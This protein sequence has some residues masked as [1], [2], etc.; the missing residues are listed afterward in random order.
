MF[1]AMRGWSRLAG[2]IAASGAA[3]CMLLFPGAAAAADLF[4]D[5]ETGVDTGTTCLQANPCDTLGYAISNS[6]AGDSI[7]VDNGTYTEAVTLN[8]GRSLVAQ[9]FVAGDG[10]APPLIDG[11]AS[12]GITA[13]GSGGGLIRGVR[14][15]GETAG[16]LLNAET[17]VDESVFDEPAAA[18]AVGVQ[19]NSGGAG[20]EV[21]DSQFSDPTPLAT[22]GRI[23][24]W[25]IGPSWIHDNVLDGFVVGISV[26]PPSGGDTIVERNE[27]TGTHTQP[28]QGK[29]IMAG[30]FSVTDE[31]I[32][33][34]NELS[35]ADGSFGNVDGIHPYGTGSVQL[36]R[37][38]ITGHFNA[39]FVGSDHTGINIRGDRY[40]GNDMS[41]IW[42]FDTGSSP[43]QTSATMTNATIVDSGGDIR[44]DNSSL[45]LDSSIIGVVAQHGGANCTITFSIGP[46]NPGGDT[47]GCFDFT[48]NAD[49][50]LVNPAL[51]NL[52]LTAGSPAIDMGNP[53]APGAGEVDFDGDPRAID[54]ADGCPAAARRDIGADEFNP[55]GPIDCTPPQTTI[56]SGPADGGSTNDPTL[57]FGFA[58]NESGSTFECAENGGSFGACTGPAEHTLDL[59]SQPDGE[60]EFEV[61]AT[62]AGANVD[63]TPASRTF[64]LD[65]AAPET[66]FTKTP[67]KKLKKKKA[68][69]SF[70]ADEESTYTCQ[71][72]KKPEFTCAG[73][74]KLKVKPGKHTFSVAATDSVGNTDPTPATHKFKRVK[75]KR[76]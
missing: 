3:A 56:T 50:E 54:G 36:V 57:S 2:V 68:V 53:A 12:A 40:W 65:R 45:T 76:R 61:R 10:S 39:V 11:G 41:G 48:S 64:T 33:R 49:P 26:S 31:V 70:I 25:A 42:L 27:I 72:D 34:D 47:S 30:S 23:G 62:D 71:L 66:R 32:L 1:V 51:G 69:F 17:V 43:P 20:S 14:V 21:S 52:H 9:D 75:K 28:V 29:S 37:N 18:G 4:V 60:Y 22:H 6:G 74:V 24:V 5:A 46:A 13:G 16:V 58:S 73:T 63:P 8:D 7:R 67:P 59:S 44:L 35:D 55:A 19:I 38:E 15:H